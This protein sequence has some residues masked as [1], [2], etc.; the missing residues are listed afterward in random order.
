LFPSLKIKNLD[1]SVVSSDNLSVP[2]SRVKICPKMSLMNYH[3]SL[4][5][6]PEQHTSHQP[7]GRSLKSHVVSDIRSF[8]L[9]CSDFPGHAGRLQLFYPLFQQ[10]LFIRQPTSHNCTHAKTTTKFQLKCVITFYMHLQLHT[11]PTKTAVP[12]RL[13]AYNNDTN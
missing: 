6:N 5:N 11:A 9:E 3:Y 8:I 4:S 7:G 1:P 2:S 10:L 13:S 12:V